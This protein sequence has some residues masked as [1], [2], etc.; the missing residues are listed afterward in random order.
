MFRLCNPR[1]ITNQCNSNQYS[2]MVC[3]RD[4]AKLL[5]TYKI[6]WYTL[7]RWKQPGY[8]IGTDRNN[9]FSMLRQFIVTLTCNVFSNRNRTMSIINVLFIL[10][11]IL[12][13]S[14]L[15]L[16]S[17]KLPNYLNWDPEKMKFPRGRKY[18][19]CNNKIKMNFL[20]L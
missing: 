7:Y 20:T 9:N 5:G 1:N 18:F 14:L 11:I 19:F 12:L 4:Q 15:F 2:E 10:G 6:I 8:E 17:S 13:F 3:V 16:K